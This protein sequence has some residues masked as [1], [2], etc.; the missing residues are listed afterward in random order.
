[1]SNNNLYVIGDPVGICK[2][3]SLPMYKVSQVE[4][5]LLFDDKR[6]IVGRILGHEET[7]IIRNTEQ[8]NLLI[9]TISGFTFSVKFEDIFFEP[10]SKF[11]VLLKEQEDLYISQKLKPYDGKLIQMNNKSWYLKI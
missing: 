3:T 1:M 7:T 11:D 2:F 8:N 10:Q 4:K 6:F 9:I 5:T